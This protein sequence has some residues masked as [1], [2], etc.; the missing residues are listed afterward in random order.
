[1]RVQ[2]RGGVEVCAVLVSYH[3]DEDLAQRIA[4]VR[5]QVGALVIVDNGSG[6]QALAMLRRLAAADPAISL[7]ECGANLGVARALNL[8]I[9]RASHGP[10]RW[11]LL[12]DQDSTAEPDLVGAL[13]AIHEGFPDPARLAIAGAAF[14]EPAAG[15]DAAAEPWVAVETAITSGSL[16][17]LAAYRAIGPF[18]EEFFID[19]VDSDF[20]QRAR[21]R[22]YAIVT[23]RRAL[24][25]H[26]IGAPSRHR[27]LWMHKWTSNHA[28]DRRYYIARNDTVMLRERGDRPFG[29]W[30]LKSLGRRLRTCK[31]VLLY[32][33]AKA[34]KTVAIFQGWWHGV[35]GRLGPRRPDCA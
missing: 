6:E 23:T 1:M 22:G 8:G 31:R 28:V 15:A 18:R 32:E 29:R 14:G 16:L 11:V 2:S 10:F 24:M 21:A 12:L 34:A 13:L 30:A 33:D 19:Y 27:L 3:P 5:P 17:A 9:E 25:S 26:V 4:A 20:C 7:L 35:R